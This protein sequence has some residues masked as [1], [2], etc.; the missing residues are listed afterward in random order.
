M[1]AIMV[2]HGETK[3]LTM[4][5]EEDGLESTAPGVRASATVAA[6]PA[7]A[8]EEESDGPAPRESARVPARRRRFLLNRA[9]LQKQARALPSA[10]EAAA[11][12]REFDARPARA[13]SPPPLPYRPTD[14]GEAFVLT[15]AKRAALTKKQVRRANVNSGNVV[16]RVLA[17]VPFLDQ[18]REAI[19]RVPVDHEAID[20]LD[21]LARAFGHSDVDAATTTERAKPIDAAPH[22][23][24]VRTPKERL[25]ELLALSIERRRVLR[26]D[27]RNL[28]VQ[29]ALQAEAVAKLAG[30]SGYSEVGNDIL[31]LVTLIRDGSPEV[32]A[33]STQNDAAL[34]AASQL[35]YDL[36]ETAARTSPK[37]RGAAQTLA[38]EDRA[39]AFTLLWRAYREAQRALAFILW[40]KARARDVLPTLMVGVGRKKGQARG[41]E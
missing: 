13:A 17:V 11:W 6:A 41:G 16:A 21:T 40:D 8:G 23:K 7:P 31:M 34:D 30:G 18:W 1:P 10:A 36:L 12:V 37:R 39:R 22:D 25:R 20:Q 27:V 14:F 28:I 4:D 15:A 38:Y 32:R 19:W 29:K 24:R 26:S 35:A 3:A 33:L 9:G 2:G 5:L